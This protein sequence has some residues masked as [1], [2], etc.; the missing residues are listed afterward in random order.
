MFIIIFQTVL[1]D[2]DRLTGTPEARSSSPYLIQFV[3]AGADCSELAVWDTTNCKH[4]IE[5]APIVDLG[6]K[7]KVIY[8][9]LEQTLQVSFSPL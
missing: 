9:E 7:E 8:Y 2:L 1:T 4:P 5:D 6:D 3:N